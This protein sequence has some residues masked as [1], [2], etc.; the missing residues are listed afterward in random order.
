MGKY[1]VEHGPSAIVKKFSPILS[2]KINESTVSGI[3]DVVEK[4]K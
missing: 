1:A 4:C 3:L 2:R